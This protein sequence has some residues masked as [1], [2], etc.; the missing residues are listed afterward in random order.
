MPR[1]TCPKCPSFKE[2]R[3]LT[4]ISDLS[5]V[6]YYRCDSCTHVWTVTKDGLELVSH[7]T[8]HHTPHTPNT[9]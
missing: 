1:T 6:D 8:I 9:H 4:V 2:P 7:V 5:D 3:K